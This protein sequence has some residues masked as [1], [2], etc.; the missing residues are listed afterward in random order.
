MKKV[1]VIGSISI[2]NVTYTSVL[3]GPG[4]TVFGDAFLSNIGGKG[5]NQACAI[6]FLGGDVE[7]YGAVGQDD[8]GA[9]I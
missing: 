3:P 2:D 4:T 9:Q 5:A 1:L 6:H 7:F 8:N